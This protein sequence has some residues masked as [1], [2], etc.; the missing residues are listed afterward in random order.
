MSFDTHDLKAGEKWLDEAA[1]RSEGMRKRGEPMRA[2]TSELI[3]D[4]N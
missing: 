2:S 3:F 4:P 1:E